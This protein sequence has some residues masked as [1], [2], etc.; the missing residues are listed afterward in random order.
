MAKNKRKK[1]GENIADA[2]KKSSEVKINF[3]YPK[4]LAVIIIIIFA[5]AAYWYLT[6]PDWSVSEEGVLAYPIPK[7]VNYEKNLINET[8]SE[9]IYKIIYESRGAKIY[10]LLR[11]PK[12]GGDKMPGAVI[13]PGAGVSKEGE[14]KTPE[15]L[16]KMGYATLT[17]DQRDT[18]ETNKNNKE[19]FDTR[20][21][22]E[23]FKN[24]EELITY[25]MAFD[26]ISARKLMTQ[27]PEVDSTKLAVI[28]ISNGGRMAIIAAG[29]DPEIKNFIGISTSG[30][31][32]TGST[33]DEQ[34]RFYKSID[35][36]TYMPLISPRK[37][38]MIHSINDKMPIAGAEKTF[39]KAKDPKKF[40]TVS[41]ELHGYCDE[42][43]PHLEKELREAFWE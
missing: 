1:G 11:I 4:I 20:N 15:A 33:K 42:M 32:I 27:F 13:L 37:V 36:D 21:D 26:V 30:Y 28:G 40:I 43:Q 39:S 31:D 16:S 38:V 24:N 3:N 5:Y 9:K 14:T 18:G 35:P 29:I 17:I 41:C 25:K 2:A 34:T 12:T 23:K 10:A 7:S 22:F 8:E 6:K 19:A